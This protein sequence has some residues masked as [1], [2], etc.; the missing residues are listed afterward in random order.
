MKIDVLTSAATGP[1]SQM[2]DGLNFAAR[3]IAHN[4]RGGKY[5]AAL[6]DAAQIP[7]AF[8]VQIIDETSRIVGHTLAY[9]WTN[10]LWEIDGVAVRHDA[11]NQGLGAA[12][13]NIVSAEVDVLGGSKLE[14]GTVSEARPFYEAVGFRSV[15]RPGVNGILAASVETV[16]DL[17][18]D[19]AHDFRW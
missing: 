8:T 7:N 9:P 11:R 15:H 3:T 2:V 10:E 12:L 4:I 18:E 17:T 5:P 1:S 13:L 6:L 19:K 14:C 16:I